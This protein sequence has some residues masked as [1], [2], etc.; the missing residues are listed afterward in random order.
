MSDDQPTPATDPASPVPLAEPLT[1]IAAEPDQP[2]PSEVF[3]VGG[4]LVDDHLVGD[5]E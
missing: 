2:D 3:P 4:A 1:G 5:E